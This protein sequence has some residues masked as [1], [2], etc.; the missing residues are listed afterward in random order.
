[1]SRFINP[2]SQFFDDSGN[3]LV[4]GKL[5]F[6]ESGTT[7][8]KNTFADV[9]ETIANTNPV[10]LS[11]SGRVPNVF[12]S[13]LARVVLTTNDDVQIWDIDPIGETPT[14]DSFTEWSPLVVYGLGDVVQGQ[15]GN[16]YRSL[17]N[18]NSNNDPASS[19]AAWEEIDFIRTWN[20]NVSYS[21]GD[22]ALG[23]DGLLY[24]SLQASNIGNNPT[25]SPSFWGATTAAVG[26]DNIQDGAVT[27]PKIANGAV[28]REKLASDALPWSVVEVVFLDSP[29]TAQPN[30][31]YNC[32][33][34]GG[35]ITI[36][37]PSIAS[38]GEP[39]SIAVKKKTA[40]ANTVTIDASGSDTV[41]GGATDIIG[42][43]V[44]RQY[45]ADDDV[46]PNNWVVIEDGELADGSV[47]TA[48]LADGAVTEIKIADLNVTTSKIADDAITNA[49]MADNS[50]DTNEVIDRSITLDK[51]ASG[52]P[53]KFLGYDGLGDPVELDS[54]SPTPATQAEQ[55]TGT[56]TDVFVTPENQKF[57][58]SASKAWSNWNGSTASI[59]SSFNFSSLVDNGTGLFTHNFT[60]SMVDVN[61]VVPSAGGSLTTGTISD[62][63]ISP[64]S[65][66]TTSYQCETV[67]GASNVKTDFLVNFINVHGDLA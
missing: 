16:L 62:V 38:V 39:T 31:L 1:M 36:N 34:T 15:D 22:I 37:L 21:L 26:T 53:D 5:Y 64:E 52:T 55:E 54:P 30:T 2:R 65:M 6:Y 19:F 67:R 66:L 46:I 48:K 3:P 58:Q 7:A 4:S 45:Q 27:T 10:L 24:R 28:T 33:T 49:K 41:G 32:D 9:N 20:T 50:V 29:V 17:I 63:D 42:A 44:T 60:N 59:R 43:L 12:F 25:L 56:A 14:G 57:N 23:S 40:D 61:Y 8:L 18:A 11:A 13:G 51:I 47:T 35:A